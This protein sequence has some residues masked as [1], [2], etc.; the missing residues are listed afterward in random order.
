MPIDTAR[1]N[2]YA[3]RM[4]D[5]EIIDKLGGTCVVASICKVKPPSVS[6][7]RRNGI[8]DA[9]RQFLELLRPDVFGEPS[10]QEVA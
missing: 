4:D 10:K 3:S 1:R 8:P 5:S 9:R 7:W 6:E 2:A